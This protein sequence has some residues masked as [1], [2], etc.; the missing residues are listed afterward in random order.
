MNFDPSSNMA[1]FRALMF[2]T[3]LSICSGANFVMFPM[4][5]RSHYMFEAK[6][7]QE[8]TERGHQV[9]QFSQHIIYSGITIFRTSDVS[10][11]QHNWLERYRGLN[12]NEIKVAVPLLVQAIV[13]SI[14]VYTG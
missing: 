1:A 11:C 8:L 7:G 4:F 9:C 10:K 14:I 12:S 13:Y 3:I 6:L 5:G 2:L